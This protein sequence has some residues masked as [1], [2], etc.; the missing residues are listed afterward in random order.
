MARSLS[1]VLTAAVVFPDLT[2]TQILGI[3]AGGAGLGVLAFGATRLLDKDEEENPAL[4]ATAQ[5]DRDTWRMPPLPELA[6]LRM[7]L[8]KKVWLSALRAYLIA[9]CLAVVVQ[10]VL[11]ALH[12]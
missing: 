4:A 3:M 7:S 2:G 10:V 6:P 12:G 8:A 11:M 5:A 1:L 9:A